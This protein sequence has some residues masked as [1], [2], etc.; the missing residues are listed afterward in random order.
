MA[1]GKRLAP[2]AGKIKG[3]FSCACA[4]IGRY[5]CLLLLLA[6]YLY[7]SSLFLTKY[8]YVHSDE[9]WLS[10]LTRQ[11]V[12]TGDFGATEAF[13]DLKERNPHALKILFHALQALAMRLGGYQIATFRLL[14]LLAAAPVLIVF[15]AAARRL[16]A[17]HS[18]PLLAA[19]LLALD[20]Q[21]IYA[22]HMARQEIFILF[23]MAL[24]LF[25]LLRPGRTARP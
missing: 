4:A 23:A 5:A 10:G 8:P 15:Y 2:D 13:F 20:I 12:E 11:I 6:A 1:V 16:F 25:L 24:N 22:S 14:S 9:A 3:A 19:A 7:G 18:L 21:F 17:G